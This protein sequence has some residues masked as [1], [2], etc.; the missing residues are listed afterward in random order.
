MARAARDRCACGIAPAGAFGWSGAARGAGPRARDESAPS[1]ARRAAGR[2]RCISPRR[3]PARADRLVIVEAG[4]VVQRGSA[5]EVT[6]RPRSKYVADLVGVNLLRGTAHAG[7]IAL[8][9]GA[10]LRAAEPVDGE[11]FAVIHP[12]AVALHR[13]H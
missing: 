3:D 7:E 12:R 6:A 8:H 4:R 2:A 10:M 11:V 5:A 9:A 1:S 13:A